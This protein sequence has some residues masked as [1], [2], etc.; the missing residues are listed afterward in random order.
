MVHLP[1][2]IT[3]TIVIVQISWCPARSLVLCTLPWLRHCCFCLTWQR[4]LLVYLHSVCTGCMDAELPIWH[5]LAA[6]ASL[7]GTE[8]P[9]LGIIAQQ[10]CRVQHEGARPVHQAL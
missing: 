5:A 7:A 9:E 3:A 10:V 2:T 8:R 4:L 6:A 1:S